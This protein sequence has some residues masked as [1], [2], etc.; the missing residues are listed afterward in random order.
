M[1]VE[2]V[3]RAVDAYA[4]EALRLQIAQHGV[5][6]A[7]ALLQ[8]GREHHR[9]RPLIEAQH[10]IHHLTDGLR[11]ERDTVIRAARGPGPRIEQAQVIVD[12]G[13]RP[14]RRARVVRRCLCSIAIAGESPSM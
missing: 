11:L 10:L 4:D 14:D 8:Q 6:L 12:L 13:H 1:G 7:F 2:V 3:N 5:V 9:R